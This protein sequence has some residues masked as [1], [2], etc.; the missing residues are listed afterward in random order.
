M[1]VQPQLD[2]LKA[3]LATAKVREQDFPL[4]QVI[5]Q[6]IDAV[7]QAQEFNNEQIAGVTTSTGALASVQVL[8]HADESIAL[9]NSR[10]LIAGTNIS[11]DDAVANQ[12]TINVTLV[13]KEWD[14]LTDGDLTQP[15]LIFA[16][17]EV[18]MLHVP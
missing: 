7:R 18:I 12:R 6:L 11:F 1:A 10:Q 8:T 17:G 9:P 15:E 4:F 13:E 2:R 14:V 3:Q 16:S 5:T